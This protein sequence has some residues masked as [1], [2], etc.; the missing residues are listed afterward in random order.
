MKFRL[1][2][3]N[4][5]YESHQYFMRIQPKCLNFHSKQ[6][7]V[8]ADIEVAKLYARVLS[9]TATRKWILN[10]NEGR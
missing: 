9:F 10:M 1:L 2:L 5:L 8:E 4:L 6:M 3:S 7:A